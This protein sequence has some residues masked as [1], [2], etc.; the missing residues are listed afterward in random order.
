MKFNI[1]L[2]FLLILHKFL[3]I[4]LFSLLVSY[5]EKL[6]TKSLLILLNI[7]KIQNHTYKIYICKVII[8]LLA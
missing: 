3:D 8:I 1:D 7:L 4:I 5:K 6:I 2:L